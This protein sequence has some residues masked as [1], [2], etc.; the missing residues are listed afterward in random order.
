LKK[1]YFGLDNFENKKLDQLQKI[2]LQANIDST[3][4]TSISQ[5]IWEKFIFISPM[6]TATS[7][8]NNSIGK[9]LEDADKL[10]ILMELIVEVVKLTNA[11]KIPIP[12]QIIETTISR[13]KSL[14]YEATSSM[15]SDFINKRPAT[16]IES[17]MGYI[18]HEGFKHKISIPTYERIYEEMT[19]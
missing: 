3:L 5:V 11:K 2:F 18:V 12:D 6:A 14:N 13:M 15:H 4:S 7:Y 16:E 17:L 9:V 10:E 8:F 19:E 1:L